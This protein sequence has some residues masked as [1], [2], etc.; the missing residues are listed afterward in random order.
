MYF[1]GL[2]EN[3]HAL[4]FP[5]PKLIPAKRNC[6]EPGAGAHNLAFQAQH[7]HGVLVEPDRPRDR[8]LYLGTQSQTASA[9]KQD[10]A[11]GQ[12]ERPPA[13]MVRD[14]PCD[15]DLVPEIGLN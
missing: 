13:A 2:A 12:V 11:A 3:R 1:A 4:S 14:V 9:L 10:A 8:D 15:N 5:N 7:Q 6:R